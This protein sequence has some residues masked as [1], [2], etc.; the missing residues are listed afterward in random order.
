[1]RFDRYLNYEEL[2]GALKEFA[3][4]H[5]GLC[6]L[7]SVGESREERAVW[8]LELTNGPTGHA[9]EKPAFWVDGNTHAGEVTGSM[10]AL[11]LIQTL[12]EGHGQDELI[13]RL[14]DEQTFYVLPRLS[15]DG[16]ERYLNTSTPC[17]PPPA[18]GPSPRR[19]P[20]C[21][22]RTSTATATSSRCAS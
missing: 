2:T 21:T 7:V 8:L 5:P 10:C 3:A 20:A 4:E 18:P 17:E 16:A 13:T 15:P 9:A 12:L 19:S 6:E 11:H 1:M 22:P 14:L